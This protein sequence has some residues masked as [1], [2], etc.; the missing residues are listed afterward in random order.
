M[1]CSKTKDALNETIDAAQKTVETVSDKGSEV[2]DNVKENM[3]KVA[4][5]IKPITLR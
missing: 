4:G 5:P 3:N 1:S 2:V